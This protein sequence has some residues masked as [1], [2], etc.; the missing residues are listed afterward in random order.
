MEHEHDYQVLGANVAKYRKARHLTQEGL[1]IK[2]NI[3]RAHISHI[4]AKGVHKVPS[5]DIV[6]RIA[7]I[8][9]VEPYRLF[10][11]E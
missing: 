4:E 8:L 2:A 11:E 3:S 7:H 9:G 10:K 5:L 1:A 6:F